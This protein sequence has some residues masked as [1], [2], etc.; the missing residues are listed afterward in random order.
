MRESRGRILTPR[1]MKPERNQRHIWPSLSMR[2]GHDRAHRSRRRTA[3]V[4]MRRV[5]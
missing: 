2:R 3:Q 4:R 5:R 1:S